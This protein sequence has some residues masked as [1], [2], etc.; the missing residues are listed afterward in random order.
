[1][2]LP[3]SYTLAEKRDVC[4]E[5]IESSK[6]VLDAMREDFLN[7]PAEFRSMLFAMICE[8]EPEN[9]DWRWD[10]LVSEGDS[11]YRELETI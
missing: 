8:A 11:L 4:N 6:A 7:Q 2:Y 9:S 3:E 10:I 5:M 1:M